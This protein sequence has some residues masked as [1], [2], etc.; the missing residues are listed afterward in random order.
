MSTLINDVKE[1]T[2]ILSGYIRREIGSKSVIELFKDNRAP[3]YR[4]TVSGYGG[5]IPLPYRIRFN[6]NRI[7]RVYVMQYG[8][9]GS[10]YVIVNGIT[11]FIDSDI[12][13]DLMKLEG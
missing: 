12:E 8:N 1:S 9:S 4:M 6:D 5:K 7:R 11:V 10:A 3:R 13:H 2:D